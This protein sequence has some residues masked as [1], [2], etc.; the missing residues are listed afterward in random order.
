ME[1]VEIDWIQENLFIR[2]KQ[3]D[4]EILVFPTGASELTAQLIS[5]LNEHPEALTA[6]AEAPD[7]NGEYYDG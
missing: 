4:N 2:L 6:D 7:G 3:G 5:C 1:P